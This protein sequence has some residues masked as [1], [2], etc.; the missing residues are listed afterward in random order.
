MSKCCKIVSAILDDNRV[1][2]LTIHTSPE[3]ISWVTIDDWFITN[4]GLL[5]C[6]A[7]TGNG[8]LRLQFGLCS[9]CGLKLIESLQLRKRS[10]DG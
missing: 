10:D 1:L 7:T 4:D 9:E 6:T 3:Q 8:D 2:K 5:L